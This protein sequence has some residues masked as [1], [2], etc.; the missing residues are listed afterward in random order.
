M[1]FLNQT[2]DAQILWDYFFAM[3]IFSS[4]PSLIF[5]RIFYGFLHPVC[6]IFYCLRCLSLEF[7]I[8][9]SSIREAA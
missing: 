9:R 6:H 3:P 1:S 4:F 5:I 8:I 7:F 2:F